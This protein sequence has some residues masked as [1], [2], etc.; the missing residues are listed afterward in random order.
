M[1]SAIVQRGWCAPTDNAVD[2]AALVAFYNATGRTLDWKIDGNTSMCSWEGVGCSSAGRVSQLV[3]YGID[4]EGT[5]PSE[6]GQLSGLTNLDLSVNS[7][8]G[9]VPSALCNIDECDLTYNHLTLPSYRR[10][11][12]CGLPA[13]PGPGYE[14]SL[15]HI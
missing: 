15:I 10:S 12:C 11:D 4:L 1:L 14:L 3:L 7:L 6:V 9:T 8:S 2:C 5:L 13:P